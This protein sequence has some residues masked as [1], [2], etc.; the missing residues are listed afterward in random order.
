[1]PEIDMRKLALALVQA[2][3]ICETTRDTNLS[4]SVQN[5]ANS[6]RNGSPGLG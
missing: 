5:R 3:Q 1:M 2:V 6:Q 4:W